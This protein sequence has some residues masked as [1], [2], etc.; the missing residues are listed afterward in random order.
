MAGA[1]VRKSNLYHPSEKRQVAFGWNHLH[2]MMNYT[3]G[4]KHLN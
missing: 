2:V 3:S 4:V 1:M